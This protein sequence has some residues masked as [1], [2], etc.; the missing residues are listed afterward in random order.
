M[1]EGWGDTRAVLSLLPEGWGCSWGWVIP[2]AGGASELC[3]PHAG[4]TG[5]PLDCVVG[6]G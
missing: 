1:V 3:Y 5:V 2:P 4:G 6:W